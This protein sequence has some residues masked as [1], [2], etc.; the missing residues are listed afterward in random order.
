[1]NDIENGVHALQYELAEVKGLGAF[2]FMASSFHLH[3]MH[4][5]KRALLIV[6]RLFSGHRV[7]LSADPLIASQPVHFPFPFR[8]AG[9]PDL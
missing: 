7:A 8:C 1:M 5:K 3:D 4:A 9:V 6:H 2:P